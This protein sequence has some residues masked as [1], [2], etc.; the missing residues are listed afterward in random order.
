MTFANIKSWTLFLGSLL[1]AFVL[2]YVM[3]VEQ[4]F[5]FWLFMSF[6][7]LLL[8]AIALLGTSGLWRQSEWH[9]KNVLL[10]VGS[11]VLLWVIFHA[12]HNLLILLEDVLPNLLQDRAQHLDSVYANRGS[13]SRL[14]VGV[15]L[16]F[17][18][19]FGEEV[20]WRRFVQGFL[21]QRISALWAFIL[22]VI[23]YTGVHIGTG[24]PMLLLAAFVCGLFWGAMYWK[25]QS[26]V[27]GLISHMLWNPLIFIIFPVQ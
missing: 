25:T 9:F 3:F 5:N 7:T 26:V 27:P 4:P 15:L 2:W 13:L 22:A 16:A 17:P 10:G 23:L 8:T 1:V 18:I 19:G 21:Q 14:V 24:N 11:A 6:S 12:G 20:F